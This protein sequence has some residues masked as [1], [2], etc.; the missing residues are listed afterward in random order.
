[1]DCFLGDKDCFLGDFDRFLGDRDLD[2]L[3]LSREECRLDE[4][5]EC[6]LRLL[7]DLLPCE[8]CRLTEE[9]LLV[10]GDLSLLSLLTEMGLK[11]L[12]FDLVLLLDLLDVTS[13][14]VRDLLNTG[15]ETFSSCSFFTSSGSGV[16]SLVSPSSNSLSTATGVLTLSSLCIDCMETEESTFLI[17]GSADGSLLPFL[18]GD[19]DLDRFFFFFFVL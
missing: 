12:D 9:C 13:L 14:G 8:E 2:L 1:M 17:S 4:R 10:G 7:E 5:E 19:L 6:L 15:E 16:V 11:D 3:R 18:V